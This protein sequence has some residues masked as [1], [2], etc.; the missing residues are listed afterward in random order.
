MKD[1]RIEEIGSYGELLGHKE[2]FSNFVEV[3][4][5]IKMLE[6]PKAKVQSRR[7]SSNS[8]SSET[9]KEDEV[10]VR[11]SQKLSVDAI[12]ANQSIDDEMMET[13]GVHRL[14]YF[15]YIRKAGVVR[16]LC[17]AFW[18]ASM[19]GFQAGAN[20]WLSKWSSDS[21]VNR[22]HNTTETTYR[23]S[24]YGAFGLVQDLLQI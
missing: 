5:N 12:K 13:G 21:V 15:N 22:M 16:F 3:H 9:S 8:T 14:I 19:I 18:I 2:T 7:V 4:S 10:E 6:E 11:F 17:A 20:V 1:G 24:I 23:L